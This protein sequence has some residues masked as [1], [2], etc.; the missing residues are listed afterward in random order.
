MNELNPAPRGKGLP[1][2]E[3]FDD[4]SQTT[5]TWRSAQVLLMGALGT[6]DVD[7]LNCFLRQLANASSP[8]QRSRRACDQFHAFRGERH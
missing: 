8:G 6:A 2:T 5:R 3:N 1:S 4:H 7:F